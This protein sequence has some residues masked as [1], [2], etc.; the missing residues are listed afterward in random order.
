MPHQQWVLL[1]TAI[2][3][4][5]VAAS[6]HAW[7]VSRVMDRIF[8]TE[9]R[10][11]TVEEW[12]KMTRQDVAGVMVSLGITNGLLGAIVAVLIFR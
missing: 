7:Y 2:G 4:F 1:A 3:G 6:V 5:A 11:S 10:L 12:S 8:E 9:K